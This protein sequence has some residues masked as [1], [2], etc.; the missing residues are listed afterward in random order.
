[1]HASVLCEEL[2]QL[3]SEFEALF[4]AIKESGGKGDVKRMRQVH[5]KIIEKVSDQ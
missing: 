1:M 4:K 5:D 2:K 3:N